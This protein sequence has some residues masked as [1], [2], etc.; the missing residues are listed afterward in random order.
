M[1]KN[2]CAVIVAAIGT[3]LIVGALVYVM[4]AYT[5]P[6]PLDQA[7]IQER[8]KALAE[9]RAANT[10]ALDN[11]A[12]LDPAKGQLRLP[13]TNAMQLTIRDYQNPAAARTNLSARADKA[14]APPPKV[15]EKPNQFE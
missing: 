13:I 9:V 10:D 1:N 15:P 14:F 11:Y 6:P 3:F 12:W 7:R 8:K 5:Q 2:F 4:R